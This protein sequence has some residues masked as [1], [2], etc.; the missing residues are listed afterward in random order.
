[1]NEK[2]INKIVKSLKQLTSSENAIKDYQFIGHEDERI[3]LMFE[4]LKTF[5]TKYENNKIMVHKIDWI[6]RNRNRLDYLTNN[7][8]QLNI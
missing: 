2:K 8:G 1:M 3:Q 7:I 6:L 4:I 5:N